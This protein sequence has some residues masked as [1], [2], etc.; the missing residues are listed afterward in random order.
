MVYTGDGVF[1]FCALKFAYL[2]VLLLK[3]KMYLLLL[4]LLLLLCVEIGVLSLACL[5]TRN[6]K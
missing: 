4:L 1:V 3:D 2:K 6:Q 5:F